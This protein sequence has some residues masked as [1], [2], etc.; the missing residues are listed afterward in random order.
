[1]APSEPVAVAVPF[2]GLVVSTTIESDVIDE[3]LPLASRNHALTVFVPVPVASVHDFVAVIGNQVL[4]V[5][6][7][8]RHASVTPD[9]SVAD[10]E[11]VT[12]DVAV[13][14]APPSSAIE[15]TGGTLS[16]DAVT[17]A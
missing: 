13:A 10:S 3:T 4:H 16:L 17:V 11:A 8:D 2:V 6:V 1:M 14:T 9:A 5:V 15:P 12:A 7:F